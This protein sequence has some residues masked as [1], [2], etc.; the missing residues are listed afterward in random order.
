MLKLFELVGIMT[1]PAQAATGTYVLLLYLAENRTITVGKLGTFDFPMGWYTYIGSAF[2][3]GGLVARLKHH[4]QPGDRPHWHIDYLR[5]EAQ[6]V[7][8]AL[9]GCGKTE[10]LG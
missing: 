6:V 5:R 8:C 4:L 7:E 2:G 9:A 10:G 1:N 3:A